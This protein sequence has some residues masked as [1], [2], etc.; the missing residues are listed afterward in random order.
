[1]N[2]LK[3]VVHIFFITRIKKWG[4]KAD[5]PI[6]FGFMTF[7]LLFTQGNEGKG[8]TMEKGQMQMFGA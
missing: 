3:Q 1:M 6:L 5:L 7:I 2:F 8:R 4:K